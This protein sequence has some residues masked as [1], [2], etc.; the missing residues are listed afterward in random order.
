MQIS[1]KAGLIRPPSKGGEILISIV[2]LKLSHSSTPIVLIALLLKR[3]CVV[4]LVVGVN[5]AVVTKGTM[6]INVAVDN[7]LCHR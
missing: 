6:S 2:L 7:P 5:V 4:K 1:I 3:V